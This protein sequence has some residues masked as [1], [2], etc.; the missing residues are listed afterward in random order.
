M[1][2]QLQLQ[3]HTEGK[4]LV[5]SAIGRV[6]VRDI[7][8]FQS[9]LEKFLAQSANIILI[10]CAQLTFISSSG[11]RVMLRFSKKVSEQNKKFGLFS[12]NDHVCN[13]FK[14]TGFDQIIT[15]FANKQEALVGL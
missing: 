3:S 5:I 13:V 9:Q 7:A 12:L 2:D 15:I 11:L 14:T 6:G 1:S 8:V 10:D 4:A